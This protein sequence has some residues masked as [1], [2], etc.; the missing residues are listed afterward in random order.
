MLFYKYSLKTKLLV[1]AIFVASLSTGCA[2]RGGLDRL[3]SDVDALRQ[4]TEQVGRDANQA[5]QENAV[6]KKELS[7]ISSDSAA[8]RKM[9]EQISDRIDGK[10]ASSTFK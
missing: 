9:L 6:L 8:S 4:L 3:Q 1:T 2:S 10:S 7:V 5:L